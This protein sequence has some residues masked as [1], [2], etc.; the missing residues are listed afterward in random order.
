MALARSL[1]RGDHWIWLTGSALGISILMISG[2]VVVILVNGLGFFWPAALEQLTLK[3][4]SVYLGELVNR[5]GIPDP[6]QP[7]HLKRQRIQLRI[8]NRDLYGFDFK[9]IDE[10]DVR[11]RERPAT[12]YFVERREYGPFLGTPVLLKRGERVLASGPEAVA[13]A[14]PGL[15][16]QARRDRAAIQAIEKDGI[17]EINYR[18]EQARLRTRRLD[19]DAQRSPGLDVSAERARIA[20]IEAEEK[21]RYQAKQ[22]ELEVLVQQA[23]ATR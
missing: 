23:A 5:E 4:G 2:L 6:G 13:A 21:T 14:L 8:G 11:R 7:D 19:F 18:I 9:W 17:G 15:L 10:D 3:D 12:A 20:R 16:E 22:A 1:R